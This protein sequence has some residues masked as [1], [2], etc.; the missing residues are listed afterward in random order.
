MQIRYLIILF[1]NISGGLIADE[2][3]SRNAV[4]S[5]GKISTGKS[6]SALEVEKIQQ[7]LP[8]RMLLLQ[9]MRGRSATG[10]TV[11]ALSEKF[12]SDERRWKIFFRSLR[13][14]PPI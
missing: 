11:K 8:F 4:I 2:W 6:G 3:G 10:Y 14:V 7:E 5:G 1:D 13:S 9:T 12:C